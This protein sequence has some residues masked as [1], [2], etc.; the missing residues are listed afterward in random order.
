MVNI[1]L[2]F[3]FAF[4]FLKGKLGTSKLFKRVGSI[5]KL[6]QMMP[7]EFFAAF[8]LSVKVTIECKI[9]YMTISNP[10]MKKTRVKYYET[11]F[12]GKGDVFAVVLRVF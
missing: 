4:R 2:N 6:H 1:V 3:F 8:F 9:M 11:H 12:R 7:S 10:N 5:F